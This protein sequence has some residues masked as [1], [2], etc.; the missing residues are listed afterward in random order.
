MKIIDCSSANIPSNRSR[1]HESL[2]YGNDS[3]KSIYPA[4]PIDLFLDNC[5]IRR[6]HPSIIDKSD[7]NSNEIYQCVQIENSPFN[8]KYYLRSK[9]CFQDNNLILNHLQKISAE[10]SIDSLRFDNSLDICILEAKGLPIKKKY[11]LFFISL[12]AFIDK[13]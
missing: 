6:I 8:E 2:I 11:F 3:L 7:L 4:K 12:L 9:E 1:S 13:F 5:Q 10:K